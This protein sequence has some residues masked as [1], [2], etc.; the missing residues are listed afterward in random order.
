MN[1]EVIRTHQAPRSALYSQAIRVGKTLYLSGM[2]GVY[3]ATNQP[4]GS[5]IQEQTRQ[6]LKN[7][8]AVLAA[9]G[10]T[11]ANVVDV[12]VLLA[13]PEDFAGL[14]EAYAPFF[15]SEPPARSVARLGPELPGLLVSIRMTA[16]L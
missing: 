1:R 8:E 15:P 11:L 9:A 3:P 5:S 7:C 4:A 10:A 6:A 16:S 13:K 2:P 14:N 12:Q